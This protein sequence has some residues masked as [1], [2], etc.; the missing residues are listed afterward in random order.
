MVRN[1]ASEVSITVNVIRILSSSPVWGRSLV[2][3]AVLA[4]SVVVSA[5]VEVADEAVVV[6]AVV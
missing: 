3:E 5:V 6:A 1:T 4:A 2:V